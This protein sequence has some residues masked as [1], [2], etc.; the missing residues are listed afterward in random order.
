[1]SS[2]GR[3]HPIKSKESKTHY[4]YTP[5][6]APPSTVTHTPVMNEA[7]ADTRK[8]TRSAMSSGVAIRLSGYWLAASARMAS[9]LLPSDAACWLIRLSQRLVAVAAGDTALTRMFD[10]APRSARP[11]AKLM[12]P[13]FA[14]PPLRSPGVGL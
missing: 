14:M 7:L 3:N 9:T 4:R 13:E 11:F 6:V 8:H 1:M 5:R 10:G 12:S 2:Q